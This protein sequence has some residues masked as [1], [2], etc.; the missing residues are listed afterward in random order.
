MPGNESRRPDR[1]SRASRLRWHAGTSVG[2]DARQLRV[3]ADGLA[4]GTLHNTHC[5]FG[6]AK[7]SHLNS[8]RADNSPPAGPFSAELRS[9]NVALCAIPLPH[10]HTDCFPHLA[11]VRA[12]SAPAC[13]HPSRQ[14]SRSAVL[15]VW[16]GRLTPKPPPI[17]CAFDPSI[18]KGRRWGVIGLRVDHTLRHFDRRSGL[19]SSVKN[20]AASV[21]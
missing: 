12:I 2:Y 1:I 4:A 16:S 7:T 19:A 17:P 13:R 21:A 15:E 5:P 6:R 9:D 18:P 8:F 14:R 3:W 11:L 20:R 10:C